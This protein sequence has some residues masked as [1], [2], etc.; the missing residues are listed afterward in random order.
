M[1]NLIVAFTTLRTRLNALNEQVISHHVLIFHDRCSTPFHTSPVSESCSQ[2]QRDMARNC[3]LLHAV[4]LC[5]L[6]GRPVWYKKENIVTFLYSCS[7]NWRIYKFIILEN[8]ELRRIYGPKCY[9][10]AGEWRKL[11]NEE[12]NDLYSSTNILR[13]IKLRRMK[14]T[15]HV[16]RMGRGEAWTRFWWGSLK[17]RDHWGDPGVDGRIILRWIFRKWD[18]EV[19]TGSG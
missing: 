18:V 5:L 13:V 15:G 8:R 6:R 7:W 3:C 2:E 19:W 14:W 12:L 16:A 4:C 11:H 10:V 17:E 1:M 9:K